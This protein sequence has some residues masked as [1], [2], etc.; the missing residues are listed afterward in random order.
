MEIK[1]V[2]EDLPDKKQKDSK[3]TS[4]VLDAF[5]LLRAEKDDQRLTGGAKIIAQLHSNEVRILM[6]FSHLLFTLTT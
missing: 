2:E 1:V 3:V 4:S 6:H 5:D